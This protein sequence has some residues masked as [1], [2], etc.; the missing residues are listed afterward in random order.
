MLTKVDL[1]VFEVLRLEKMQIT[2]VDPKFS[3]F[4]QEE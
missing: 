4:W 2:L 1:G 3:K